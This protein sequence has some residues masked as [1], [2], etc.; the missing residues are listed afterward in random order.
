MKHDI[1][2]FSLAEEK[3]QKL[4][5][6]CDKITKIAIIYPYE[7]RIR[8]RNYRN[9]FRKADK[10]AHEVRILQDKIGREYDKQRV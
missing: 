8:M 5:I 4:D 9:Y 1:T 7:Q 2:I 6:V 3:L 10:L